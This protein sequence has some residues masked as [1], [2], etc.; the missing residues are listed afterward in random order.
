[1][2]IAFKCVRGS[3]EWRNAHQKLSV[4]LL[5]SGK[6][7]CLCYGTTWQKCNLRGF[8]S[9]AVTCTSV[10]SL[11]YGECKL[12]R[13][14]PALATYQNLAF[15]LVASATGKNTRHWCVSF[16]DPARL[17]LLRFGTICTNRLKRGGNYRIKHV[18]DV[19]DQEVEGSTGTERE[20]LAPEWRTFMY[21]ENCL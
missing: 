6:G 7:C 16:R 21:S 11:R 1:M 17:H 3:L 14:L 4:A 5:R 20:E 18:Q 19:W 13:Q 2:K 10:S 9:W 12:V 15:T 8:F